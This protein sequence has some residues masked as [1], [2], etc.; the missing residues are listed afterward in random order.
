MKENDHPALPAEWEPFFDYSRDEVTG[1]TPMCPVCH[2]PLYELEYC[3]FCGQPIMMDD[4]L[5]EWAKPPEVQHTDCFRC[6]GKGTLA[7]VR[8][9]PNN[10]AHGECSACGMRFME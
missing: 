8:V 3:V 9:K 2:E 4:K 10:H 6:G 7:F 5:A 1:E